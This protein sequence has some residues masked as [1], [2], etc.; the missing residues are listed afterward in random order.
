MATSE[1]RDAL[2]LPVAAQSAAPQTTRDV[3]ADPRSARRPAVSTENAAVPTASGAR[4]ITSDSESS[5]VHRPRPVA[6]PSLPAYRQ[7]SS[8]L[9]SLLECLHQV[10]YGLLGM[11]KMITRALGQS[12]RP[13]TV[14]MSARAPLLTPRLRL[15]QPVEWPE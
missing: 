4:T 11:R 14:R 6:T 12:C 15:R 1:A 7:I 5:S 3:R 9:L 2:P 13:R 10:G 8:L